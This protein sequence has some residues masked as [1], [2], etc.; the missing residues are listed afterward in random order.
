MTG[1]LIGIGLTLL[2]IGIG[3]SARTNVD[4]SEAA[5][6]RTGFKWV[7]A[8]ILAIGGIGVIIVTLA[9]SHFMGDCTL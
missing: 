1:Y 5:L 7:L 8:N 4:V 6:L 9:T 2:G 3:M